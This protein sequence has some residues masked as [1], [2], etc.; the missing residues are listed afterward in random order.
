MCVL[1]LRTLHALCCTHILSFRLSLSSRAETPVITSI[2]E[3]EQFF[4]RSIL[5]VFLLRFV[6]GKECAKNR[7]ITQVL[8]PN[9]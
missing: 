1:L 6:I 5:S 8:F 2:E 3:E 9:L 4:Y 7:T